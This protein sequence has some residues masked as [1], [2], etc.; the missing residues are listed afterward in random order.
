[1]MIKKNPK[2]RFDEHYISI[3]TWF[4][5][6]PKTEISLNELSSKLQISK[7]SAKKAINELIADGFLFNN[8][9]GK[10][11]RIMCN[12]HH[13]FNYSRKIAYNLDGIYQ[14]FEQGL[15]DRIHQIVRNPKCVV[16][17]GSYRKGDDDENSDIDIAMEVLGEDNLKIIPLGKV[18]AGFRHDVQ[19]NLHVFSRKK[20]DINLF[21]NIAN[22]FVL[23][24]FLEVRP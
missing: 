24:G 1:M 20:I 9:Y 11:W 10:S 19:V 4:F 17:F 14:L 3:M 18:D 21:S 15:K 7:T 8:P 13:D 12:S 16:L 2:K 6:Y 5:S 22:G 23:E